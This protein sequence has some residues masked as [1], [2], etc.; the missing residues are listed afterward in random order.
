MTLSTEIFGLGKGIDE[1]CTD[2][3]KDNL[4]K[5]FEFLHSKLLTG[6]TN[7]LTGYEQFEATYGGHNLD[8]VINSDK[9]TLLLCVYALATGGILKKTKAGTV[10]T[11]IFFTNTICY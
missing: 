2:K 5:I 3:A 11:S 1:V 8:E 9:S 4:E 7:N 6:F 10:W